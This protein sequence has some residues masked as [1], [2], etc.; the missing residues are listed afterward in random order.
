MNRLTFIFILLVQNVLAAEEQHAAGAPTGKLIA[1]LVNLA[2]FIG[3]IVYFAGT[4]IKEMV[5]NRSLDMEKEIRETEQ[6]MALL[7]QEKARIDLK[8]SQID[9]ERAKIQTQTQAMMGNLE[10]KSRDQLTEEEKRLREDF[11]KRVHNEQIK[12]ND[13]AKRNVIEQVILMARNDLN[14]QA[15][16]QEVHF[17]FRQEL[18]ENLSK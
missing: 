9:S 12:Q 4:Q 8:L 16:S 13:M 15:R 2:I 1:H 17:N 14:V 3:I 18:Q 7:E 11:E 5:K 10:K 6:E